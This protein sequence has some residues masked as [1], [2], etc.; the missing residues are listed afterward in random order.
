DHLETAVPTSTRSYDERFSTSA[1]ALGVWIDDLE[2]RRHQFFAVVELGAV[3][4]EKTFLVHDQTRA[5]ALENLVALLGGVDF[6]PVLQARAFAADD[7]YA[8]AGAFALVGDQLLDDEGFL[9]RYRLVNMLALDEFGDVARTCD[10]A[11]ASEGL[12]ARILEHAVV[13]D[14]QLQLHH[15]A[16]LRRADDA[17]ADV[18]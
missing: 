9:N 18:G 6:H 14:L 13:A 17:G 8:Q 16:T 7:L 11:A 2:A 4:I 3:E 12:E 5:V 15:V 10:R 1:T